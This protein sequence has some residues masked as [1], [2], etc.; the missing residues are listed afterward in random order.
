MHAE[1]THVIVAM[2]GASGERRASAI[3]LAKEAGL[4][5]LTVPSQHELKA[6]GELTAGRST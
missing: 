3:A 2:P 5:V 4:L 1:A 6:E